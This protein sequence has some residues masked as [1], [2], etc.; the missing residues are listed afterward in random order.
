[1]YPV[2]TP[3]DVS[4]LN[5]QCDYMQIIVML[6]IS[7]LSLNRRVAGFGYRVIEDMARPDAV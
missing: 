6:F 4:L 1:M 7:L 3:F 5:T 2:K